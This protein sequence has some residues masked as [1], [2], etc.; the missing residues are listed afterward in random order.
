MK[1]LNKILAISILVTAFFSTNLLA[2]DQLELMWESEKA[3]NLPESAIFDEKTKSIFEFSFNIL[4]ES[5]LFQKLGYVLNFF[6]VKF[7][8]F[9]QGSTAITLFLLKFLKK[10]PSLL[11]ISITFLGLN[12]S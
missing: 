11:P 5:F 12:L 7:A 1:N 4:L 10:T 9:L 2:K 6:L 3:F 8:K